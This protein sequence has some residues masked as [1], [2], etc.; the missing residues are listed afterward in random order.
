MKSG[1]TA[2]SALNTANGLLLRLEV[3]L[4]ASCTLALVGVI[5]IEVICRY[6]L[7]IS[8]AWSEE[9]ARYLFI[10]MTYIGSSYALGEGGHIEIDVCKQ[11]IEKSR[12]KKKDFALKVLE[13]L[14]ILGTVVFLLIFC[15][16]FWAFMMKIWTGAQESPTMHIPMGL[17]YLPVFVASVTSIFH[18]LHHITGC[19]A[20]KPASANE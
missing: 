2:Y 10:W 8:T 20:Q 9:L 5:F 15:K 13:I 12:F 6:W 16:I 4:L 18:C 11:A 1:K 17:V 7:F 19:L 14:S 3:F